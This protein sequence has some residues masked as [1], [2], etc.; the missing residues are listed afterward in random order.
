MHADA[1]CSLLVSK[2]WCGMLA[3]AGSHAIVHYEM[4]AEDIIPLLT[5][6]AD[7]TPELHCQWVVSKFLACQIGL[8]KLSCD[9]PGDLEHRRTVP[10][11]TA[12][13]PPFVPGGSIRGPARMQLPVPGADSS[14][15][16][17][18]NLCSASAAV[19]SCKLGLQLQ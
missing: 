5:V 8:V 11:P 12:R 14:E 19:H 3:R 10:V 15:V 18:H 2:A 4:P 13:R 16:C 17:C 9:M 6:F 1:F 7:H